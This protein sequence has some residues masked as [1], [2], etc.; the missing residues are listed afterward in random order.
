MARQ[1]MTVGKKELIKHNIVKHYC[2]LKTWVAVGLMA[3]AAGTA[4]AQCIDMSNLDDGTKRFINIEAGI[5]YHAES[6]LGTMDSIGWKAPYLS[7]TSHPRQTLMTAEGTDNLCKEL[8]VLPPELTTSV[9]LMND[10]YAESDSAKG[11][12]VVFRLTVD[13]A[14]PIILINYAAVLEAPNH[15]NIPGWYQPYCGFYAQNLDDKHKDY[16]QLYGELYHYTTDKASIKGWESFNNSERKDVLTYWKDW[17][18]V[19]IDLSNWAGSTVGIVLANYDCAIS[20]VGSKEVQICTER[21]EAHMYAHVTCAAKELVFSKDCEGKEDSITI[22]APEGFSYRWY[23]KSNKEKILSEERTLKMPAADVDATYV[24][25]LTNHVG[26]FELEQF[27]DA[28]EVITDDP[29]EVDFGKTFTWPRSGETISYTG[30]YEY[31]EPYTGSDLNHYSKSCAKKIYRIHVEAA[32]LDCPGTFT[33]K[34][35]ICGDAKGFKVAFHYEEKRDDTKDPPVIIHPSVQTF[36]VDFSDNWNN[37]EGT[38][39]KIDDNTSIV[40]TGYEDITTAVTVNGTSMDSIITIPMPYDSV[41]YDKTGEYIYAYPR[42]D[43]YTMTLTVQNSCGQEEKHQI[44][45]TVLYPAWVIYQRWNDIL[46]IK[47]EQ[48]NGGNPVATVRWFRNKQEVVGRGEHHSYIHVPDLVT[49]IDSYYAELTRSDDRKTFC[50]CRFTPQYNSA[51]D[52]PVFK[53]EGI[54]LAPRRGDNRQLQVLTVT[55]G[56]YTIYDMTGRAVQ[57]GNYGEAYGS[58]DI[59]INPSV[60]RGTYVIF[61]RSDDGMQT[62]KKWIVE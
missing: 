6:E 13:A 50:T 59:T 40:R 16:G 25:E 14:H 28:A 42:P 34:D 20:A 55:S 15:Y 51:D 4:W 45:F 5:T 31:I 21:H 61:F 49:N 18:K 47:N 36:K 3:L 22:T 35:S 54:D 41:Y 1:I 11:E 52:K 33:V 46:S 37:Q 58:P 60:T 62:T 27:V 48:F 53:G 38:T 30:D 8:S 24:C 23:E 12:W 19:G 57:Q 32:S 9:R 7:P 17:S 44:G 39:V 43:D 29:V 26:T 2:N 56:A 10:G